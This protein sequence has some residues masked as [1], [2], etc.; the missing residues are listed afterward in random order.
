LFEREQ[1][2]HGVYTTQP[3]RLAKGAPSREKYHQ[4]GPKSFVSSVVDQNNID[5]FFLFSP[6]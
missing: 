4:Q 6:Q 1:D 3:H 2:L 5:L